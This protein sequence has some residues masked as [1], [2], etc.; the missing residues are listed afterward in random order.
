MLFPLLKIENQ[1]QEEYLFQED[2]LLSENSLAS[3]Y[4]SQYICLY[5]FVFIY[6]DSR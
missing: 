2:L 5:L 3:G 1:I 6:L 4:T